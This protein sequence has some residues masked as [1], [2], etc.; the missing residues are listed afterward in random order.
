MAVETFLEFYKPT[1][2]VTI[3]MKNYR[4]VY[5][6]ICHFYILYLRHKYNI[7]S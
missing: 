1:L 4:Q 5:I 6:F 3:I 7:L 2:I